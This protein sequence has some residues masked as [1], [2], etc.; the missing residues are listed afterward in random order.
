VIARVAV[1][2]DRHWKG[3]GAADALVARL[4]RRYKGRLVVVHGDC[5]TG[6]DAMVKVACCSLGVRDE[7]HPARWD[8]YGDRAGPLRNREMAESGI[9]FLVAAHRSLGWSRGTRNMALECLC[10]GVPVYWIA[11]EEVPLA[12]VRVESIANHDVIVAG[13]SRERA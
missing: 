10:R 11:S 7:P 2:G 4:Q 3:Q 13:G 6:F 5:P 8:L 9:A 1:S 12:V